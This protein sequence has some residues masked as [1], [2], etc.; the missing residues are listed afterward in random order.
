MGDIDFEASGI[1]GIFETRDGRRFQIG[2][3]R[4]VHGEDAQTAFDA[5][6]IDADGEP[7]GAFEAGDDL[8][9]LLRRL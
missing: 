4:E 9:S 7:S 1:I 3:L 2:D 6:E 5:V 8:A